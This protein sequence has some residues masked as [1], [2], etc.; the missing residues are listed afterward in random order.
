MSHLESSKLE[1]STPAVN[2]P[3]TTEEY[4]SMSM[5]L[6]SSGDV[7][8]LDALI[9]LWLTESI[10]GTSSE[11]GQ[12]THQSAT[13]LLASVRDRKGRT[14]LHLAARFIQPEM[15]VHLIECG[16]ST[17]VV[18]NRGNTVLHL[19]LRNLCRRVKS[20]TASSRRKRKRK[21][22]CD[23]N[24]NYVECCHLVK[25]ILNSDS[26]LLTV[27]NNRG[28]RSTYWLQQLWNAASKEERQIGDEILTSSFGSGEINTSTKHDFSARL[29]ATPDQNEYDSSAE[30]W[31]GDEEDPHLGGNTYDWEEYFADFTYTEPRSHLDTVRE[32]YER[33]QRSE[34]SS[35]AR[36]PQPGRSAESIDRERDDFLRRHQEALSKR[37]KANMQESNMTTSLEAF[38]QQW[39]LFLSH[40]SEIQSL[41][42]IPWPPFCGFMGYTEDRTKTAERRIQAVL[43]FVRHQLNELRQLQIQWHPDRFASRVAQRL[44]P[45]IRESVLQKVNA[46]SQLL[47]TSMDTLR[48]KDGLVASSL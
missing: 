12:R 21:Q 42:T 17:K 35:R 22:H 38:K 10:P 47:N 27:S 20:D 7:V 8:R 34:L 4:R 40:S 24:L 25:R 26:D 43:Q 32:E 14:L 5:K 48:T 13:G 1:K 6:A 23:P 39:S 28:Q 46:I 9:S 36:D 11:P 30:H 44:H 19:L 29:Y 18:D 41:S 16:C 37:G 2:C 33:R 31:Y 3:W 45:Q 15:V